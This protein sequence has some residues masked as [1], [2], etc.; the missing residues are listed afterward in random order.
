MADRDPF[1]ISALGG[2]RAD[3]IGQ[4]ADPFD[5]RLAAIERELGALR[6][7]HLE[8]LQAPKG[9]TA[10]ERAQALQE[11]RRARA[12]FFRGDS[13]LFGEPA[14]DILLD[15]FIA[16]E[17]GI[18]VPASTACIDLGMPVATSLRWIALIEQRGLIERV[19]DPDCAERS[20]L[21]LTIR[22]RMALQA[23]LEAC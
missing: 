7:E 15:I 10:L 8:R 13:D 11:L 9:L 21:R 23:Y 18:K 19:S 22:A 1:G 12:P 3:P 5:Q 20:L 17:R 2:P 6:A 4:P 14:W 16:Q